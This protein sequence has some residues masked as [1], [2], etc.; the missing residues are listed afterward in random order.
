MKKIY[1]LL[2]LTLPLSIFAK[3][4]SLESIKVAYIYNI[5]KFVTW[6]ERDNGSNITICSYL[7]SSINKTIKTLE[8]QKIKDKVI[9]IKNDIK[10]NQLEECQILFISDNENSKLNKILYTTKEKQILTISDYPKYSTQ[11]VIINLYEENEK[12]RFKINQEEAQNYKIDI[13]SQLLGMAT[14]VKTDNQ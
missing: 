11:G 2:L 3:S 1:F 4:A 8:N 9:L 6:Q 7:N 10:D 13:S 12:L 14:I 5:A